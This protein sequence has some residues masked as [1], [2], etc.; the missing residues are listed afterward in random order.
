RQRLRTSSRQ[1]N[2]IVVPAIYISR[3]SSPRLQCG[4]QGLVTIRRVVGNRIDT[5]MS[6]PGRG[7]AF[8]ARLEGI[9]VL[10]TTRRLVQRF[11]QVLD[12]RVVRS[13]A[14]ENDYE[15]P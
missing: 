15:F 8:V 11:E 5:L 12:R 9:D 14:D 1:V 4:P 10:N 2:H 7:V 6:P 3:S 13:I